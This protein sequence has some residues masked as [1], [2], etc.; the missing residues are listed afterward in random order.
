MMGMQLSS[1]PT[2]EVNPKTLKPVSARWR[3]KPK[4]DNDQAKDGNHAQPKSYLS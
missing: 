2:G 4:K 1:W 3:R